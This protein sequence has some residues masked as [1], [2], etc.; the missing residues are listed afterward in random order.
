MLILLVKKT[1][2]KHDIQIFHYIYS[3]LNEN[4]NLKN[5]SENFYLS[6]S[7]TSKYIKE[8]TGLSFSSLA[9]MMKLIKLM[10]Y[11]N[12]S[13]MNLEELSVILGFK[14]PSHLSK[15]FKAKLGINTSEFKNKT[16]NNTKKVIDLVKMEEITSYLYKYYYMDLNLEDLSIKFRL[17]PTEINNSFDFYLDKSFDSYLTYIRIINAAK[18]LL[19]KDDTV[20]DIAYTVGFNTTKTFNRNFKKIYGI[21]P[22]DFRKKLIYQT[23]IM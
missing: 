21:N 12:F 16:N 23:E 15:F 22:S 10:G 1:K 13:Q 14:D 18:I 9:S 6:Q 5:I 19:I 11:L 17:N 7:Q 3:H 8:T 4:I 2:N 20:T